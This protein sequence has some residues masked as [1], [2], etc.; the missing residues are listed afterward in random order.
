VVPSPRAR[1]DI[2]HFTS[3]TA[4]GTT[5]R[6]DRAGVRPIARP[7][8]VDP[9]DGRIPSLT[10]EAQQRRAATRHDFV[11]RPP[12][13]PEGSQPHR[14]VLDLWRGP[15]SAERTPAPGPLGLLPDRANARWYIVLFLE[16][17]HEAR[18]ISLERGAR[19]CRRLFRQWEG[20]SRGRWEGAD[21]PSSTRRNFLAKSDFMG[22]ADP[23]SSRRTLHTRP[24]Q[25]AIEYQ[26]EGL[27]TRRRGTEA[28]DRRVIQLK[29][30]AEAVVRVRHAHRRQ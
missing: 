10:A 15:G 1:P 12:E 30:S 17:V 21:A 11:G 7:L 28:L 26:I 18:I 20:D 5:S 13:G 14:T 3:A 4:T 2:A 16:A 25:T 9:P 29:Q 6:D 19:T 24:R 23:P 8:V 22:S 27:T